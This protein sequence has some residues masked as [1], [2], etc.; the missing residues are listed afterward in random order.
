[1]G[2]FRDLSS[3]PRGRGAVAGRLPS[4]RCPVI[5]ELFQS[6]RRAGRVCQRWSL[7]GGRGP[8][9]GRSGARGSIPYPL[10]P[11]SSR[12]FVLRDEILPRV[13][14]EAPLDISGHVKAPPAE[15]A[16]PTP[17]LR[18]P[19]PPLRPAPVV[20]LVVVLVLCAGP[21][22]RQGEGRRAPCRGLRGFASIPPTAAARALR[23]VEEV[24][25]EGLRSRQGPCRRVPGPR[26]RGGGVRAHRGCRAGRRR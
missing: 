22:A 26:P 3:P 25:E 13:L 5:P 12:A 10:P 7:V 4:H 11:P 9:R 18:P 23:P 16:P 6:S 1:M 21:R 17:P 24:T 2:P 15:A 20:V 8:T 19:T 14:Q